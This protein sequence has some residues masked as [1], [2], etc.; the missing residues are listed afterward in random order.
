MKTEKRKQRS[1][2]KNWVYDVTH[3][4]ELSGFNFCLGIRLAAMESP[5]R[6]KVMALILAIIS[7]GDGKLQKQLDAPDLKASL[8]E[9]GKR[10]GAVPWKRKAAENPKV[11]R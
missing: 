8:E 6:R 10:I 9:Y 2:R 7:D 11:T 4:V 3:V 1:I 5:L